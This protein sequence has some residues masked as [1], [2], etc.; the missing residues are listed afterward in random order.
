M[1]WRQAGRRPISCGEQNCTGT[2]MSEPNGKT[3]LRPWASL[4][5]EEQTRLRTE[6]QPVL[7]R[8]ATT[9][10]LDTKIA[11]F[12]GW[13]ETKGVKFSANDLRRR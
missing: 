10:S 6:Y 12:A 9:C 5:S 8:E 3:T 13:L 7:D 11:R 4:S 1:D 2:A